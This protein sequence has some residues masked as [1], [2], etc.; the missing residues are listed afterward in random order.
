MLQYGNHMI[1]ILQYN[2]M[3]INLEHDYHYHISIDKTCLNCIIITWLS[4]Y[5]ITK[6]SFCSIYNHMIIITV[7]AWTEYGEKFI[8]V[9]TDYGCVCMWV[10][11]LYLYIYSCT[12][13]FVLYLLN[14]PAWEL[15]FY[16]PILYLIFVICCQC[17][18][19]Y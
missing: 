19:V 1:I 9:F 6:L 8:S 10:L 11:S 17:R 13:A 16:L 15:V 7:K 4:C 3:L 2:C 5:N 14:L 12:T 18:I